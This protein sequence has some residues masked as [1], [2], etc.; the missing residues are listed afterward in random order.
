M[1]AMRLACSFASAA[2]ASLTS[3]SKVE[4]DEDEDGIVEIAEAVLIRERSEGPWSR[5]IEKY[6]SPS[7]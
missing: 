7:C 2:E 1:L 4:D 3:S 5:G 6:Q